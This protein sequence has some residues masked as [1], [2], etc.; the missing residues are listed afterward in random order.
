MSKR[1]TIEGEGNIT[2]NGVTMSVP[3]YNKI[4]EMSG[5]GS[6]TLNGKTSSIKGFNDVLDGKG[7]NAPM[8]GVK[9]NGA[10]KNVMTQTAPV[11]RGSW[12]NKAAYDPETDSYAV[13]Q[14]LNNAG[15]SDDDIK[16]DGTFVS[17]GSNK[18]LPYKNING[19]TYAPMDDLHQF[20]NKI[21]EEKGTPLVRANQYDNDY[22]LTGLLSYNDATKEVLIDGKPIKYSYIDTDGNA[23]VDK[24]VIDQA[25][26]EAAEKRG[27]KSGTEI[28]RDFME[29]LMD[30][31]SRRKEIQ[32]KQAAWDYT[33]E[34]VKNDPEYKARERLFR[35]TAMKSY[36]NQLGEA[37]SR[38]GGNLSSTAV[39]AAGSAYN[40][41]MSGL[42]EIAASVRDNA[43]K[44]FMDGITLEKETLDSEEQNA[45]D[46]YSVQHNANAR[47]LGYNNKMR[48]DAYDRFIRSMQ[49]EGYKEDLAQK[50]SDNE[51]KNFGNA[52]A[53]AEVTGSYTDEDKK[54]YG[55][56]E[57][58]T[59]FDGAKE[60]SK[61]EAE[62][63][64]YAW[65]N[66]GKPIYQEQKDI[67]TDAQIRVGDAS[68][69]NQLEALEKGHENNLEVIN[70]Q[71]EYAMEEDDNRHENNMEADA[72]SHD[73]NR[74][75]LA[76]QDGYDAAQDAAQHGYNMEERA[77]QHN[78]NMIEQNA[79]NN[80]YIYR[81]YAEAGIEEKNATDKYTLESAGKLGFVPSGNANTWADLIGEASRFIAANQIVEGSAGGTDSGQSNGVINRSLPGMIPIFPTGGSGNTS[82]DEGALDDEEEE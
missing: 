22:G 80:A 57:K 46:V 71:H 28:D 65:D 78:Y 13:R 38:N 21:Y 26:R 39:L 19:V 79:Q 15:V 1:P 4:P 2:V 73:R 36:L 47:E 42:D 41:N 31:K 56:D 17:V 66:V 72:A 51:Y 74:E 60:K 54:K 25:Y 64:K 20:I 50:S 77:A 7:T 32:E 70:K 81:L 59:P 29:K 11:A 76:L 55:L 10:K 61:A 3:Q 43:Y 58:A 68:H 24:S 14:V 8:G 63:Q 5:E 37:A 52:Q 18:Y 49:L 75:I 30:I 45:R 34:D 27:I 6:F 12:M 35:E 9:N 82:F 23:W 16:W 53:K 67:D 69:E 44:R 40:N 62:A 48:E 33:E